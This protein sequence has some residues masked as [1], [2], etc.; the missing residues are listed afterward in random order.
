MAAAS[1]IPAA[2]SFQLWYDLIILTKK[3]L[4]VLVFGI[5]HSNLL[6][7][8]YSGYGKPNENYSVIKVMLAGIIKAKW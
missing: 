3:L 2:C 4:W 1:A 5:N 6:N 8:S 7:G